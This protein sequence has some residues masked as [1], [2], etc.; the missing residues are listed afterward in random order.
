M[1]GHSVAAGAS[2]IPFLD[3]PTFQHILNVA[4]ENL[5]FTRV[6]RNEHVGA[7][8]AFQ[9]MLKLTYRD[10]QAAYSL[11][12]YDWLIWYVGKLSEAWYP[13][14]F[15]R[16]PQN[17]LGAQLTSP[18]TSPAKLAYLFCRYWPMFSHPITIWIQVVIA[19]RALCQKVYQIPLFL[20]IV[21]FAGAASVLAV[22][23]YAFTG[24][25]VSTMAILGSCCAAAA[26]FQAWVVAT[27]IA[28]VPEVPACFPVDRNS[29]DKARS[30]YFLSALLFDVVATALF[31]FHVVRIKFRLS[32]S[33]PTVRLLVREGA[34][35]FAAI[36]AVNIVS[37]V[38][39]FQKR[40]ELSG[41]VAPFSMLL[42]NVF[43][44]RL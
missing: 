1:E 27:Q 21:N 40:E 29:G 18:G 28:L 19:D 9:V 33:S 6:T 2:P 15:S 17:L 25:R 3:G 5:Y 39:T 12:I 44:C 26:A 23:L 42:P 34:M 38:M 24:A 14:H 11:F 8:S 35:Y 32:Q 4:K 13:I 7:F 37:A 31:I 43:A 36:A 22:R 16:T 10:V 20:T 30:Q 41:T